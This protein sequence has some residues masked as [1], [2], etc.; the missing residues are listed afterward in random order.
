[1]ET[2]RAQW[3]EKMYPPSGG[4]D[5]LGLGSV[6][7]DQILPT[8][9]PDI[10]VQT[11]HPRYWSFYTFL[12]DEFWRRDLPRTR[13]DFARFYRPREAI[14]AIGA[15]LCDRP[16]HGQMQAIVGA[17]RAG[18]LARQS[19]P[20]R[21]RREIQLH[22]GRTRRLRP[23]LQRVHLGHGP[24]PA[25]PARRRSAFRYPHPRGPHRRGRLP[26]RDC[27]HHLLPG[28]LR[29]RR[30]GGAGRSSTGI[31]AG[32]LPVPAPDRPAPPTDRSCE[33]SSSMQAAGKI[34]SNAGR[35][36]VFSSTWRTRPT[37]TRS[38][39]TGSGSSPTTER[40]P[41]ARRGHRRTA[42]FAR[43]AAG[44]STKRGSTTPTR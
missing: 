39:R 35:R 9:S 41:T 15:H 37:V 3:T 2:V 42:T 44:G 11:V 29:P 36:Y 19:P 33:T 14:F 4:R 38:T 21:L 10:V 17:I 27:R 24:G 6:S 18:A 28:T 31:C 26:G 22:Q 25:A 40:I 5:H 1:M 43:P 12:L 23:L 8:L 32:C 30:R 20:P 16:E 13:R 7:S 34:L